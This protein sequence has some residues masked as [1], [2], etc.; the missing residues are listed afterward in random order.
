MNRGRF[1]HW[2]AAAAAAA[3]AGPAAGQA[4]SGTPS[5]SIEQ[6]ESPRLLGAFD[7]AN[8]PAIADTAR[9]D[10]AHAGRLY[11]LDPPPV[12]SAGKR[13][14]LS[15]SI[16]KSTLF[17]IAGKANRNRARPAP[18]LSTGIAARPTGGGKT[19]GA[20]IERRVGAFELGAVYQ[21]SKVAAEQADIANAPRL[22]SGE[23]SH[24]VRATARIRF[25]P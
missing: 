23:K 9:S 8:A 25:R 24:N 14:K 6:V 4:G 20:G 7:L 21:Y 16:G 18:E 3:C 19:Y 22:G 12:G 2:L 15:V 1:A 5:L 11:R 10:A 13:A 17:A